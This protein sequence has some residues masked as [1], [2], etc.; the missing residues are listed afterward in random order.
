MTGE[1]GGA[2]LLGWTYTFGALPGMGEDKIKLAYV[3]VMVR[4][5]RITL[6][7]VG[8]GEG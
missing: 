1:A 2:C 4:G 7:R 5:P 3:G 8:S 6:L